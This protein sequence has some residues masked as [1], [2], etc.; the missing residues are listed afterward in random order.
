M[1]VTL[2]EKSIFR[3]KN[4]NLLFSARFLTSI[5]NRMF[6]TVCIYKLWHLTL[7][8]LSI[9]W[10]GL[11]IFIPLFSISLCSSYYIE[12]WNK[13]K[14][15]SISLIGYII[16]LAFFMFISTQQFTEQHSTYTIVHYYYIILL[17]IGIF[18]SFLAPAFPITMKGIFH[19]IA[20]IDH[21]GTT[22]TAAMEV[23]AVFGHIIAGFTIAFL[24]ISLS[25]FIIIIMYTIPLIL[26]LSMRSYCLDPKHI[27]TPIHLYKSILEG[28]TFIFKHS[29]LFVALSINMIAVIFGGAAAV[30]PEF[31]HTILNLGAIT[32]GFLN[33]A[34]PFGALFITFVLRFLPLKEKLGI[35]LMS[36]FLIFGVSFAFFDIVDTFQEAFILL[37][38]IGICDGISMYVRK[39]VLHSG[40]PDHLRAQVSSIYFISVNSGN[41]LGMMESGITSEFVGATGS[42]AFGGII[43]ML[44]IGYIYFKLPKLFR[45]KH[46]KVKN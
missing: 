37:S 11:I 10:A 18:R 19:D 26:I 29:I 13:K 12:R 23:A 43:T 9:G 6:I 17:F 8:S 7:S 31:V 36:F 16:C 40:T 3:D 42:I 2:K 35:W 30:L 1:N 4:F 28:F 25:F 22:M 39:S 45:T 41:E 33:A 20:S 14:V 38:M 5:G 24:G 34:I 21:G 32:F 46:T 44:A 15:I 27:I